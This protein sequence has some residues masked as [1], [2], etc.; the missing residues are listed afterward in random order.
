LWRCPRCGERFITRNMWHSCRR[1]S[2]RDLF[3]GSEPRVYRL[4][5][6]FARMMRACGPVRIIGQKT[7]LVFQVRVRFGG[8]VPRRN[9]LLCGLAFPRRR[10]SP[11]F[12]KTESFG[13]HFHGHWV[14]N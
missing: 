11:R 13:K 3:R 12:I 7:R 6:K 2:V 5:L 1:S 9:W 10:S 8:C 14:P 4:Y